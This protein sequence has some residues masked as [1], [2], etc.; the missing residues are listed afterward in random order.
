MWERTCGLAELV[1][2]NGTGHLSIKNRNRKVKVLGRGISQ[3]IQN[4]PG[5][6]RLIWFSNML[7]IYLIFVFLL[8]L[9][10]LLT[11]IGLTLDVKAKN[12]EGKYEFTGVFNIKWLLFSYT[13]FPE[14][15]EKEKTELQSSRFKEEQEKE[16]EKKPEKQQ[17]K[18]QIKEKLFFSLKSFKLLRV[19]LFHLFSDLL[20]G[21]DIQHLDASF[22]FGFQDPA[23]TGVVCGFLHGL[24]GLLYS[25]CEK[26]KI[27]IEPQFLDS[28]LD[29]RGNARINIKIYSLIFPFIKFIINRRTLYFIFL[30]LRQ[31][32][33]YLRTY[34]RR[35]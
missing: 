6:P 30:I 16:Q 35:Q 3:G 2:R 7:I 33:P 19:P 22:S 17:E 32:I 14:K 31:K 24:S 18:G 13:F 29:F 1:S 9:L 8:L 20:K 27:R 11:R 4:S 15:L 10:V 23:D 21:I 34:L 25:R 5:V 12:L 28:G 26:C